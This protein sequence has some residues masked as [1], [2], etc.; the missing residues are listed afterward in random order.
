MVIYVAA[1]V[2]PWGWGSAVAGSYTQC[3]AEFKVAKASAGFDYIVPV[4][5]IPEIGIDYHVLSAGSTQ[6]GGI[7]INNTLWRASD[8]LAGWNGKR[9]QDMG[10]TDIK[11]RTRLVARE[12]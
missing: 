3:P 10:T 2:Q 8:S 5:V 4:I 1:R 12:H 6:V 9:S 7:F 11:K